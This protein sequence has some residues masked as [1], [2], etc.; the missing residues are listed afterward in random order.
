MQNHNF[1]VK[2]KTLF[3]CKKAPKDPTCIGWPILV[4]R[5]RVRER[6]RL[7]KNSKFEERERKM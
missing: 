6:V 2:V 4:E 1:W 3:N 7:K 5:E